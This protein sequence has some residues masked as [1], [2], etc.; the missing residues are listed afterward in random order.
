MRVL[1]RISYIGYPV[2]LQK[3]KSKD[4]LALLNFKNKINAITPAYMAQ[5]SIKVR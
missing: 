2:Q 5:L 4:V 1:D 3:S